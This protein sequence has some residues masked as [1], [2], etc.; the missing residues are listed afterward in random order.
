MYQVND[1][2]A[3]KSGGSIPPAFIKN[4]L[5]IFKKMVDKFLIIIYNKIKDKRYQK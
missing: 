3:G 2:L 1:R 5:K 4:I